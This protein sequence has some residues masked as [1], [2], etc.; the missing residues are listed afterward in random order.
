MFGIGP[1]EY[2][3][4]YKKGYVN[5]YGLN[6]FVVVMMDDHFKCFILFQVFVIYFILEFHSFCGFFIF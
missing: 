2:R 6:Y 3:E 5:E 4:D 1:G